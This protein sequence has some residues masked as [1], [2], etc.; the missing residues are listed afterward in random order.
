VSQAAGT[1]GWEWHFV[2]WSADSFQ[3]SAISL[4]KSFLAV[5]FLD[6]TCEHSFNFRYIAVQSIIVWTIEKT[7]IMSQQEVILKLTGGSK[8]DLKETR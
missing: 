7:Q 3:P 5:D 4:Q 6:E 2:P 8:R 1:M